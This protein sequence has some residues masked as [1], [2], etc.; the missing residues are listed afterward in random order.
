[1]SLPL[2]AAQA[3]VWAAHQI[4]PTGARYNIAEYITLHGAV[5][6]DWL[7]AAWH[8]LL[9]DAET[10]RVR[11]VVKEDGELRQQVLPELRP[12]LPVVD[13]TGEADPEAAAREWMHRDLHR[14]VDL[15]EGGLITFALLKVA[16]ERFHFYERVHHV[17]IDGSGGP[18]IT[19]RMAEVYTALARGEECPP[20][21]FAPLS[22]L[23]EEDAAYRRSPD[24][25]ADRGHWSELLADAPEPPRLAEP[26]PPGDPS[27]FL[28]RT[29]HLPATELDR[30]RVVA[31]A[32]RTRWPVVTI[33]AA[34]AY[35]ARTTGHRDIV[36]GLPV[37]ARTTPAD[38]RTPVLRANVVPVRV[39]IA[40]E[41]TLAGL[42]PQVTR[43]MRGAL[44]HQRYR[45]ED[46]RRDLGL[47][48]DDRPLVGPVVN[49]MDFDYD[50]EFGGIRASAHN[51]SLGPIDELSIAAYHRA[52]GQGLRCDFDAN[53]ALYTADRL[54]DHQDR[55]L[56]FLTGLV[57]DPER[58]TGEVDVLSPEEREQ[59]L[60]EANPPRREVPCGPLGDLFAARAAATPEALAVVGDGVALTYAELDA[61]ANRLAHRL[62]RLGVTTETPVALLLERSADAVAAT[63]AVVRAG[64]VYVPLHTGFPAER[65]AWVLRDVGATLL[66]T[67]REVPDL[68]V[69]TVPLDAA[70]WSGEGNPGAPDT[71]TR[72]DHL[73]YVMYTSGSTGVPKGVAIRHRDVA[74][75][76]A[77]HR[78]RSGAHERILLH[79]PQSFDAS[80]YE[81]WVPLLNG[82]R[83]VVAP[84]GQVDGAVLARMV[85]EHGVTAAFLTSALFNLVADEHPKAFAGMRTVWTGGDA[86]SAAAMGRVLEACPGIT[87]GNGYGPTETTTFAVTDLVRTPED[88][89]TVPP[90]GLPLDN[91]GAYVLDA[92][93]RLVPPGTVGELYV[94]GS[95]L[96]RGYVGRPDLTA[97]RFVACP[98]GEPGER[99]YR[100]GDLVRRRRDGRLEFV[101]RA[102]LQVKIRGFRIE[103][104]EIEAV[105]AGH[106]SVAQVVVVARED[107]P[108][109]K[110]LVAYVVPEGESADPSELRV[111]VG[112]V[113]PE[114]MVPVAF[115]VVERLPLTVNGKVDRGA[116][117]APE[118]VTGVGCGPRSGVEEVLCGLFAEVLGVERVGVGDSFFDCGGDSIMAI[119]LV[120]RARRAG[121]VFSAREVFQFP[122]VERLAR[123]VVPV[124]DVGVVGEVS[125]A[126]VGVVPLTPVMGW[127]RGLG[128]PV[129]GFHQHVVV[130]LPGGVGRSGLV[131]AVQAVVDRHDMV[132]SRLVREGGQWRLEVAEPG[133]VDAD[134]LLERVELGAHDEES[135]LRAVTEQR[136]RAQE[137]LDPDAGTMLRA[138]WLDE[139]WLLLVAHHLVVDGVSWRIIL[140]DLRAAWEGREPEPVVSSFR[141]WSRRLREQ[142][143]DGTYAGQLDLWREVIGD[144]PGP[145]LGARPLDAALD[146]TATRREL[147]LTLPV[148][149]TEALLT[150]VPSVFHGGVNDVLLAGL[151]LAVGEWCRRRGRVVGGGVLVDVEGHGR[152]EVP[153]VDVSRTVGW[154]TSIHPVRLDAGEVVWGQV[155]A[156]GAVVG[157]V[158]KGVKEQ[159]RAVPDDGIGFG[160]LRY[161]DPVA[162][163]ELA[164]GGRA[165]LG[166][167]Y[168]GRFT[169]GGGAWELSSRAGMVGGGADAGLALAHAVEVNAVTYDGV[170]GP[171]LH[172]GWA[173]ADGVL[174]EGEVRELAELWFEALEGLAVHAS[175]PDAGGLTPSDLD[176][177]QLS[178]AEIEALEGF[179]DDDYDLDWEFSK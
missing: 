43:A 33:T 31:R 108:G 138:V 167:N 147:S 54:A 49:I 113:L 3:G 25:E 52:D 72:P 158:V 176:L 121:W 2:S 160:V 4:D 83:V 47:L 41:D 24:F 35:L 163:A 51:L 94:S 78:W 148:G 110:R 111:F 42:V 7:E 177:V 101:G 162:G 17:L 97:E 58:P 18:L 152:V 98:Y 75:F 117:P 57:A 105:L 120:S 45:Y 170:E 122:S 132:R 149:V 172:A 133:T 129:G 169:G 79:A 96:A 140:E 48:G 85:A 154:F 29:S 115:V 139:G 128:G 161:L 77:D 32:L 9:S 53:P 80:T 143:A 56:R 174:S 34:A 123:V 141:G 88:I 65:L 82:G 67:D 136:A 22:T 73:A 87:V 178:Q 125:G 44:K 126:G 59:L 36:L 137:L 46:M 92:G 86:A 64:G 19:G 14:P 16:E 74:G 28:R 38:R 26:A 119:Q 103:L 100:T 61:R 173:W 159:V 12:A 106:P 62:A 146:T 165:E 10:L 151:A 95:G 144:R 168:L 20:S 171:G 104:G 37:T 145:P 76:A 107:R 11:A 116:L 90:I 91:M 15:A 142:A 135:V 93:L 27:L 153:G 6:P 89:G 66:L 68:G 150:R 134:R 99:M 55:Y 179:E 23:L 155:R 39:R 156:G 81:L 127:L 70:V 175:A 50:L 131:S 5:R 157:R 114:Y 109:D 71:T 63:L 118:F 166:F 60:E 164:G 21:T 124:G 1:M 13:L 84:P 130:R 30:M 69:R 8:Q 112:G 40:P 102:D